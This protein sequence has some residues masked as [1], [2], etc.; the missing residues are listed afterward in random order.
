MEL[1][2]LKCVL[3]LFLARTRGPVNLLLAQFNPLTYMCTHWR[4]HS[5]PQVPNSTPITRC[6]QWC[7]PLDYQ[8]GPH[9]L[10]IAY[11][12][13][14]PSLAQHSG[15]HRLDHRLLN[16]AVSTAHSGLHRSH[17]SLAAVPTASTVYRDRRRTALRPCRSSLHPGRRSPH[18]QAPPWRRVCATWFG[19]RRRCWLPWLGARISR[20]RPSCRPRRLHK[21]SRRVRWPS[22]EK[23]TWPWRSSR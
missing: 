20:M 9:R 8:S 12:T 4:F 7:P 19:L 3:D 11:G 2:L 14:R 6:F 23:Q 5:G 1:M 10:A 22:L 13:Q 21:P 18:L 15:L 17:R 16:T